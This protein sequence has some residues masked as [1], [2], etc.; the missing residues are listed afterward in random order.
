VIGL[1]QGVSAVPSRALGAADCESISQGFLAQPVAAV[2]SLAFLGVAGW[3]A[4]R[5]PDSGPG[6]AAAGAYAGLVAL[7][8]VGS[9]AYH[10]PQG[11]AAQVLHDAPI[12]L[13]L[14]MG[15]VV[16]AVHAA[17]GRPAFAPRP[18]APALLTGS[19]AVLG[20]TA[21]ALGRTGSAA[22]DPTSLVQPHAAWHVLMAVALGAWG[23]VLWAP[24]PSTAPAGHTAPTGP[25]VAVPQPEVAESM[26]AS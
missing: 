16:P 12:A 25:P 3:L 13:V 11:P 5:R 7:V 19:A 2:S 17:R 23:A 10:G 21:Y 15:A 18:A 24:R 26:G 22:C 8:G 20:L 14:A 4:R 6:R 1:V 9:V